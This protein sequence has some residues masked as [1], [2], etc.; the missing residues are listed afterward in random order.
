MAIPTEAGVV[1][2]RYTVTVRAE[3]QAQ[4]DTVLAERLGHDED[5]GFGYTVAVTTAGVYGWPEV[6]V[7]DDSWEKTGDNDPLSRLSAAIVLNGVPLHVE[8]RAVQVD[9][10]SGCQSA[11]GNDWPED[12][13]EHLAAIANPDGPFLTWTTGGREYVLLAFPFC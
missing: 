6:T 7:H 8:A 9:E 11:M 5:Y 3:T 1:D 10:A 2:F 13:D 4:A 12:V